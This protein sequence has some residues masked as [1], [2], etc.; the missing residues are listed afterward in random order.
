MLRVC[1]DSAGSDRLL[2]SEE[3]RR[4]AQASRADLEARL[5]AEARIRELEAELVRLPKK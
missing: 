5:V 1:A 2:S 4:V 3:A